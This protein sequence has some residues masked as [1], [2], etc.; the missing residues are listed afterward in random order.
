MKSEPRKLDELRAQ[1]SALKD[2]VE[3][4]AN[5]IVSREIVKSQGGSV[6]VF[7]FDQGQGLSEHTAPFDALVYNIEGEGEIT[8]SGTKH[9]LSAGDLIIMPAH[10][11]H[12][13]LATSK[14]KMLL[15][16]IKS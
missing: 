5:S 15:V 8:I 7:A 16:M 13:L 6:T 11:P 1:T 4:A 3:Y 12:A 10:E 2:L 14:F 9:T